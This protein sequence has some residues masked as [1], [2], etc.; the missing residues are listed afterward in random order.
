MPIRPGALVEAGF[1]Y[2]E[3][4]DLCKCYYCGLNIASWA[5][6]D[7]PWVEHAIWSTKC[8]FL[9]LMKGQ[10]FID[11][12]RSAATN[13]K[14]LKAIEQETA[15][16]HDKQ[17]VINSNPKLT[18]KICLEEEM[19]LVFQPCGHFCAC[20]DCGLQVLTCPIC[21]VEIK[22]WIKLYLS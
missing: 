17:I 5:V 16:V 9:I 15:K 7:V 18:C 14:A 19:R 13:R 12:V 8:E 21:R 1:F 6:T 22:S 4:V 10:P 11:R 3:E 2:T 20:V